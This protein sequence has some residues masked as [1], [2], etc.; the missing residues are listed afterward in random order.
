MLLCHIIDDLVLIIVLK[1]N[2]AMSNAVVPVPFLLSTHRLINTGRMTSVKREEGET[3]C[4]S[5]KTC[6]IYS[7][8]MWHMS[9]FMLSTG[10][11]LVSP[12]Q[13]VWLYTG[14]S[15]AAGVLLDVVEDHF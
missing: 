2:S 7:V 12:E 6:I 9:S 5:A 11:N 1:L 13:I 15:S 14:S 8:W 10:L 3:F 4:H